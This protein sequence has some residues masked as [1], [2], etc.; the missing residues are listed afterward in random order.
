MM[1]MDYNP[2]IGSQKGFYVLKRF[3]SIDPVSLKS[4]TYAGIN[5]QKVISQLRYLHPGINNV[6]IR[7][8]STN[9]LN[10]TWKSLNCDIAIYRLERSGCNC[11][12]NAAAEFQNIGPC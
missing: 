9:L 12:R 1:V 8:K 2:A 10:A 3:Q 11:S 5:N 6:Y 4:V 7:I